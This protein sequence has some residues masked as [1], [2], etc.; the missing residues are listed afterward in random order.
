[1]PELD[2]IK[3]IK[4]IKQNETVKDIPVIMATGKMM[5]VNNLKEALEAGAV[6]YI[7]QQDDKIELIARVN[8]MY[9][10]YE[11]MKKNVELEKEIYI[12]KEEK[13]NAII[14]QKKRELTSATLKLMQINQ[15]N[16]EIIPIIKKVIKHTNSNEKELL[17]KIVSKLKTR[18]STMFWD[19]FEVSFSQVHPHFYTNILKQ[20]PD[21]TTND[22]RLCAFMSMN[23]TTKEIATILQKSVRSIEIARTR[24]RNK[25]G[26][27]GK[28]V[29]IHSFLNGI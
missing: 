6:D 20:F 19:E 17:V 13:L 8:S 26:I 2:G 16:N 24:L 28:S 15:F 1:M 22:K 10:L 14:E 11:I 18:S 25:L 3:T 29:D 7:R 27:K 21:L 9:L 12:Q 4:L 5:H 23:L